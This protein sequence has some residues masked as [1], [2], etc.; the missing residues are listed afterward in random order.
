M[1]SIV[2]LS[3]H[4]MAVVMRFPSSLGL[5]WI[6]RVG[7]KIDRR[8]VGIVSISGLVNCSN[9]FRFMVVG[10]LVCWVLYVVVF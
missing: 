4:T 7:I 10:V 1:F 9:M 5:W 6:S 2:V 3:S 8:A